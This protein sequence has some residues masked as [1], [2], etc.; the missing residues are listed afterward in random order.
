MEIKT[1][2]TNHLKLVRKTSTKK[3]LLGVSPAEGIGKTELSFILYWDVNVYRD[4]GKQHRGP[5]KKKNLS[6]VKLQDLAV[7]LLDLDSEKAR[8]R[9]DTCTAV[10][11]AAQFTIHKTL[12]STEFNQSTNQIWN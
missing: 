8:I 12:E 5:L 9:N 3:D 1:T 6:I 11:R 2:I 4:Y 10:F 7:L